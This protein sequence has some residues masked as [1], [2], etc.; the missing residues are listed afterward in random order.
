MEKK[1]KSPGLKTTAMTVFLWLSSFALHAE[2]TVWN[3]VFFLDF[4]AIGGAVAADP[5][6]TS[7][8]TAGL[9]ISTYA[10]MKNDLWISSSI[11]L[12]PDKFKD[13]F[14]DIFNYA[15]DG[16]YVLAADAV[17]FALGGPKERTAAA[18][19]V[20]GIAVSGAISYAGKVIF[21][22]QRPS[23]T[24]DALDFKWFNF[25]DNS[26]PSG[27]T[28]AAFTCAAIIGDRYDIG[29]ITYPVAS[30]TGIARIY[31]G[32]HWASDV[33]WGA[34]IGTITGKVINSLDAST[35]VKMS[36]GM[37]GLDLSYRF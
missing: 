5:A 21:G 9:G 10:L 34:V 26:M 18:R 13:T 14:F 20:E 29:W 12:Y 31:K 23:T 6:R 35:D 27:H 22:R 36:A 30:L 3:R 32:E 15:G 1:F 8:I 24:S 2:D 28:T 7:V 33:L 4:Q 37:E 11:R 16:V 19:I 25:A 17:F